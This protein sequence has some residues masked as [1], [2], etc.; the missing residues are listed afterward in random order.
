M[1]FGGSS[2]ESAS[3]TRKSTP[4]AKY[5]CPYCAKRFNRPSS[6][7]IHINTHTGEKPFQCPHPGC[8][9][10]FSVQSNMRRHSRIHGQGSQNQQE[11]SGDEV[12]EEGSQGLPSQ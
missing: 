8:G 1:N 9:R 12:S 4:V 3:D 2:E 7:K 10:C 11:S 6:L 5:E